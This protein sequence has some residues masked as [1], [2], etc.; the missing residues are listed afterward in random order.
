M[1]KNAG[2]LLKVTPNRLMIG[3]LVMGF[4][5]TGILIA[6]ISSKHC[7]VIEYIYINTKNRRKGF[8]SEILQKFEKWLQKNNYKSIG[9]RFEKKKKTTG[10]E[11]FLLSCKWLSGDLQHLKYNLSLDEHIKKKSFLRSIDLK[12][13]H[14][15]TAWHKID[16]KI[17]LTAAQLLKQDMK[18]NHDADISEI[19][20]DQFID[21]N[22]F[23]PVTSIGAI[24][25]NKLSGWILN[26]KRS[27]KNIEYASLYVAKNHRNSRLALA[28]L[29]QS[30]N[31]QIAEGIPE[32]SC[33]ID[34]N[35]KIMLN[36]LYK[37]FDSLF[38]GLCEIKMY[39]KYIGV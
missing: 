26:L 2:H 1:S 32:I 19:C 33:F 12:N 6:D 25:N 37:R 7:A 38:R 24:H 9:I 30:M 36:T 17:K 4:V 20:I 3:V 35:N 28:L 23:C 13:K 11:K 31:N 29:H 15:L 14:K 27:E 34:K 5:P 18:K 10:L 39:E 16:N 21:K 8:A 22:L